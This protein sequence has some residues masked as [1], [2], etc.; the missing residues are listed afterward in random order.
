M[1]SVSLRAPVASDGPAL[2]ELISRCSPLDQNSRYCNLLQVTHFAETSIVA[3]Q[4][5]RLIGFV[6]GYRLPGRE[7]V[8][9]VWQVGVSNEGRGQGLAGRMLESLLQRVED[10]VT[11]LETTVTPD[12]SASDALFRK[13][14][15][16]MQAGLETSVLFERDAHFAG[17][18]EREVLYRIGPFGSEQHDTASADAA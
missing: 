11:H 10:E 13:L 15:N 5:G 1:K 8:L 16:R 17:N 6:T 14:A 3:E 9:F 7:H 12:N 4:A 18:H 2:H